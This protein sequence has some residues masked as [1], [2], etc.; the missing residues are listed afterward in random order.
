VLFVLTQGATTMTSPYVQSTYQIPF[1]PLIPSMHGSSPLSDEFDATRPAA[2][3]PGFVELADKWQDFDPG[4]LAVFAGIK[5]E[6]QA[7]L[8]T[9]D[10]TAKTWVG[11]VQP[12][13]LPRVGQTLQHGIYLRALPGF[14]E[15]AFD[16][17]V[18]NL[19]YGL[20]LGTDMIEDPAVSLVLWCGGN[21]SRTPSGGFGSPPVTSGLVQAS[22]FPTFDGL[23]LVTGAVEG[24]PAM[25]LF[26]ARLAQGQPSADVYNV[27]LAFDAGANGVDWLPLFSQTLT[28]VDFN[29]VIK[30][31]GFGTNSFDESDGFSAWFD[32]F[33]V[34]TQSQGD[35]V[36]TIGGMQQLGAV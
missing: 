29:S 20:I 26:R 25:T 23:Q 2:A 24:W 14:I 30:Q 11:R 12:L 22:V 19:L 36:S 33:R 3:V 21:I 17:Q 16:A 4:E 28:G 7:C 34:Q 1:S 13:E 10:G 5:P 8:M 18:T 35:L 15:G 6:V 9:H 32:L 31:V 27:T